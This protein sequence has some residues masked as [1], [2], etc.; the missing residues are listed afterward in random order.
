MFFG[1]NSSEI[2][3][4]LWNEFQENIHLYMRFSEY[5][6]TEELFKSLE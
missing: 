6:S 1:K 5:N 2:L 4:L 3:F